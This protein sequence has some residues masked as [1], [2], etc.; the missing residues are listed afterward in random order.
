M[1]DQWKKLLDTIVGPGGVKCFCCNWVHT[2]RSKTILKK[3]VRQK[4]KRKIVEE[5]V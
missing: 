4:L 1:A 5:G 2:K 3:I